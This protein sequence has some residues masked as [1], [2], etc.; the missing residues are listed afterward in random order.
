MFYNIRKLVGRSQGTE[1][2]ELVSLL[3]CAKFPHGIQQ[4]LSQKSIQAETTSIFLGW[5]K[6]KRQKKPKTLKTPPHDRNKFIA[7]IDNSWHQRKRFSLLRKYYHADM[8][9]FLVLS[10]HC[11]MLWS[12]S[13]SPWGCVSLTGHWYMGLTMWILGINISCAEGKIH[14]QKCTDK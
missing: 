3:P 9:N 4:F 14:I 5:D 2:T 10:K 11:G 8:V 13:V 7:E 1:G 6:C 12:D